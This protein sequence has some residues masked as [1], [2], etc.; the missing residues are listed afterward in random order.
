MSLDKR[1]SVVIPTYNAGKYITE[2]LN[3]LLSQTVKP[4]EIIIIDSSSTDDTKEKVSTFSSDIIRFLQIPKSEFDHGAT[5]DKGV[6][7]TDSE[8]VLFLTQDALP[9]DDRLIESM[10]KEFDDVKVGAVNGRQIAYDNAYRYEKE[11]R[12]FRYSDTY[13][14]WDKDTVF[15][16]EINRYQISD[17]CAMYRKSCYI[18]LGGF[19][20]PLRL[21]EDILMAKKLIDAGYSLVYLPDAAVYHSHNLSPMA[22]YKRNYD[23]G[24]FM[25]S[26]EAFRDINPDGEGF[27]LVKTVSIRLLSHLH[28]ISFIAFGFDCVARLLGNRRGK[29]DGKRQAIG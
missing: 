22:Q 10:V 5:R 4:Q 7:L 17:V 16:S 29:H 24:Y 26:N 6:R 28:I 13:Q 23:I 12:R 8:L 9:Y 14:K 25:A 15:K 3:R 20:H 19:P 21:C 27:K 1:A 2:Q 11:V 18:A